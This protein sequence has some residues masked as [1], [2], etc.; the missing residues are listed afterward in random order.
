VANL[1]RYHTHLSRYQW[2]TI[3]C[4]SNMEG[5]FTLLPHLVVKI[6]CNLTIM[7]LSSSNKCSRSS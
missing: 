5:W 6:Q 4:R 1:N 2:L 7:P 3:R